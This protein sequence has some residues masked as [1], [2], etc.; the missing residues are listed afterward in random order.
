[1]Q[2]GAVSQAAVKM[3]ASER[4]AVA[5]LGSVLALRMFGLFVLLPVLALYAGGLPG[6]TPLLAGLTVGAF[7]ITQALLQI[8]AGM[9]SDRIGRKAV[10]VLGLVVFALG[11]IVAA[12]SQTI[13]GVLTGR[14]LQ[15]A[16]AISAA[17]TA[18]VADLTRSAVRTRAMAFVGIAIGATFM[19]ALALGPVLA[20]RLGVAG[21]FYLGAVFAVVATVIVVASP[22]DWRPPRGEAVFDLGGCLANPRLAPL[23]AGIFLLHAML[24]ATFVAVPFLLRDQLGVAAGSHSRVYLVA[25][26]LSLIGTVPLIVAVERLARPLLVFA[27]G[28]ALLAGGQAGL[29]FASSTTAVMVAMAF[30]FAGFNFIEARLPA[31]VSQAA[32]AR[33]RG[34]AMGVFATAQFLGAFT[35]GLLGGAL[36]GGGGPEAVFA[37]AG[38]LGLGWA[39]VVLAAFIRR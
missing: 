13:A 25:M 18:L 32:G 6:G 30:F 10:I 1:M 14:I 5:A 27:A 22:G 4:R 38:L 7:G 11:S 15:G 19:L 2:T 9:L 36:I 33:T 16:G 8:P 3:L 17:A 35:G 21:L 29:A 12:E 39:L 34:A 24:T 23:H 31:Q 28:V 20:G 26:A 37:V